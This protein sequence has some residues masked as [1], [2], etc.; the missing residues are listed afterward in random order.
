MDEQ[1]FVV[2]TLEQASALC[3]KLLSGPSLK[4]SVLCADFDK[5]TYA[6]DAVDPGPP[7]N[8]KDPF[9]L[10]TWLYAKADKFRNSISAQKYVSEF[11]EITVPV[12]H[13]HGLIT[14][15]CSQNCEDCEYYSTKHPS[16]WYCLMTRLPGDTLANVMDTLSGEQKKQIYDDVRECRETLM[17]ITHD[18]IAS[19]V[20]DPTCTG[21]EYSWKVPTELVEES[22]DS[23]KGISTDKFFALRIANVI[24]HLSHRPRKDMA[25]LTTSINVLKDTAKQDKIMPQHHPIV[26]THN[27]MAPRNIMVHDGLLSGIIDWEYAGFYPVYYEYYRLKYFF[28]AEEDYVALFETPGLD[29][30]TA[31]LEEVIQRLQFLEFFRTDDM[32]RFFDALDDAF[33]KI[34]SDPRRASRVA[35]PT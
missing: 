1:S 35:D 11:T 20:W 2:T 34:N 13:S 21:D 33:T 26:L 14:L 6:V 29:D 15:E 17:S 18:K 27:D 25:H 16:Y 30:R 28:H 7:S 5:C 31:A 3:A 9:V 22:L 12:I 10:Q 4:I 32:S 24:K 19:I 8:G 23:F